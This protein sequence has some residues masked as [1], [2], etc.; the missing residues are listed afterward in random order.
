MA[1]VE[2]RP[3]S[4]MGRAACWYRHTGRGG[5]LSY[6]VSKYVSCNLPHVVCLCCHML[7]IMIKLELGLAYDTKLVATQS[8]HVLYKTSV[9]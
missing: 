8:N 6:S 2:M 9:A 1:H 4:H 5:I 7:C 3:L